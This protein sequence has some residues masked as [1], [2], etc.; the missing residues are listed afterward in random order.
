MNSQQ[1][2]NEAELFQKDDLEFRTITILLHALGSREKIT[3]ENFRVQT[4]Q[5]SHLK[6]LSA[7]SSLLVRDHETIAVLLRRSAAGITVFLSSEEEVDIS[8][9]SSS[10]PSNNIPA[11]NPAFC[12]PTNT[13]RLLDNPVV[14][15]GNDIGKFLRENW[16]VYMPPPPSHNIRTLKNYAVT[17]DLSFES[18]V[19]AFSNLLNTCLKAPGD[20]G[21]RLALNVY[22]TFQSAPKVR[23]RLNR[24]PLLDKLAKVGTEVSN[25]PTGDLETSRADRTIIELVLLVNENGASLHPA[26]DTYL[27]AANCTPMDARLDL[28]V[29]HQFFLWFLAIVCKEIKALHKLRNRSRPP[30]DFPHDEIT[31]TYRNLESMQYFAWESR[32]FASYIGSEWIRSV[33]ENGIA[34]GPAGEGEEEINRTWSEQQEDKEDDRLDI[35]T[36]YETGEELRSSTATQPAVYPCLLELRLIT[37]NIQH[38]MTLLRQ[39]PTSCFD[40]QVIQYRRSD[41]RAKPW[42]D[43]IHELFPE[44]QDRDRVLEALLSEPGWRFDI[45]RSAKPVPEFLG[46]AH[47]EAVL[48]CLYSLATRGEDIPW[49][50]TTSACDLW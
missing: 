48:G 38:I 10:M 35:S 18:H 32:F 23:R 37:S 44:E 9:N 28:S 31:L 19:Q 11:G 36:E 6:P 49:V 45:F 5:R 14:E 3:L 21:T 16:F 13:V 25:Y 30:Q 17:R 33:C 40:L 41:R 34:K 4:N 2:L 15:V 27:Y 8:N 50:T 42:R 24:S 12:D 43:L 22:S 7:L 47:C 20:S 46:Q 39:P 1:R 29:F 26:L